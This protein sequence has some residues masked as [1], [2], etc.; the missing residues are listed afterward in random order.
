[1]T[2]K[3]DLENC[4]KEDQEFYIK[5]LIPEYYK[6]LYVQES[7]TAKEDDLKTD[8]KFVLHAKEKKVIIAVFSGG[9]KETVTNFTGSTSEFEFSLINDNEEVKFIKKNS[10]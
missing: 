7:L 9:T 10:F 4:S 5:I 8:K 2:C 1:V 3:L 6:D